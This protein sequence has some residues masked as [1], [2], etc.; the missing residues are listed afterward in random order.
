MFRIQGGSEY[1]KPWQRQGR[2]W[3]AL[4]CTSRFASWHPSAVPA[5]HNLQPLPM[6]VRGTSCT[7]R[8]WAGWDL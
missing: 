5:E 2:L 4:L 8:R 3:L 6:R 1:L 7:V